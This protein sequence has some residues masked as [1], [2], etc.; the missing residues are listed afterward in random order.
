M[1]GHLVSKG[2]SQVLFDRRIVSRTTPLFCMEYKVPLGRFYRGYTAPEFSLVKTKIKI[3]TLIP[4][5]C[6]RQRA[7]LNVPARPVLRPAVR[8]SL[9]LRSYLTG[10][11]RSWRVYIHIEQLPVVI[12]MNV[13]RNR[14]NRQYSTDALD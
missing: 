2:S 3:N 6:F 12:D 9:T 11:L 14:S 5:L 1:R 4:A 10:H 7:H 8:F 13:G